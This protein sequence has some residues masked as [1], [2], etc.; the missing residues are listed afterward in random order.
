MWIPWEYSQL[1]CESGKLNKSGY[2]VSSLEV[3]WLKR[4]FMLKRG[5]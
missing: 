4:E 2:K 3:E 5:F 1:A